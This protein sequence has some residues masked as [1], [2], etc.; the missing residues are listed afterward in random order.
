[1]Y[2]FPTAI[3]AVNSDRKAFFDLEE[4]LLGEYYTQSGLAAR[5]AT[6]DAYL[7]TVLTPALE[8]HKQGGAVAEK[9]EMAYLRPLSIGDPSKAEAERAW[10][11]SPASAADYR[12][13]Q[14]YLFR[15][16]ARECGRL[17]MA[18]HIHTGIGAG[19][20]Y[21]TAGAHPAL[22]E[23]LLNDP[24]LRKTNF[25]MVHGGWPDTRAVAPLLFKPNV[26]VDFSAQGILLPA[27]DVAE[28]LRTW[29][30]MTPEKVL[31]GTDAYPYAPAANLGWEET[32][33]VSSQ[34]A[35][36]ALGMALTGMLRNGS[37][38]RER[39]VEIGRMALRENA[40]KLYGLK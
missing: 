23:P 37:V 34:N 13:L 29:L 18:V 38:T 16:I 6:L 4:K 11:A 27:S 19:G 15:Q 12:V 14:D 10:R 28:T 24:A 30:E 40:V 39:A 35:R 8:R 1:M 9:F 26:Y 33:Y 31:F 17:G 25:V 2:P 7:R 32:A 20:Y 3:L 21:D 5:P 22:L 36:R